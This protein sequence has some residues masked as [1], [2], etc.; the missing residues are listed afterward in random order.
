MQL[1]LLSLQSCP[2]LCDLMDGS[3]PGSSIPGILQARI[4][5][6][7]MSECFAYVPP[8]PRE[9]YGFGYYI[10]TFNIFRLF[11]H[12]MWKNVLLFPIIYSCHRL[13]DHTC[14]GFF[15]GSLFI[16]IDLCVCFC[17]STIFFLI[18]VAL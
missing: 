18:T 14:V 7:F 9:F 4:L 17:A 5:L 6:Q 3:P 10:E 13:L 12:M 2:I 15:L 8:P 11:L 1:L 16:T